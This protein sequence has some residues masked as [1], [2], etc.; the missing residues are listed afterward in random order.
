MNGQNKI[1]N[2]DRDHSE[3]RLQYECEQ[4]MLR[5][6]FKE[7]SAEE[8]WHNFQHRLQQEES[9]KKVAVRRNLHPKYIWIGIVSAA[10]V[11]LAVIYAFH[12]RFFETENTATLFTAIET[13]FPVKV[14]EQNDDSKTLAKTFIARNEAKQVKRGVVFS[15]QMAD[16]SQSTGEG[17]HTTVVSIPYGQVYKVILNDGTEVWLNADSRLEFPSRFVGKRRVVK[18]E[19]EAYFHVARDEE[20][21]FVIKTKK[22]TTQVLGTEFNVKTYKDSDAHVTLVNGSVKVEIP[23]MG[24]DVLLTPGEDITYTGNEIQIKKVDTNY[25]TQWRDGYFYFD[26]VTLADI[27]YEVGRW[28]NVTIEMVKDSSLINQRL[29]FIADRNEDIDQVVENLNAFEYLSVSKN[30]KKLTVRR[31]R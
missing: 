24:K 3:M 25:Y 18:L 5:K 1:E 13:D 2:Q 26:D 16:Y 21:P 4:A 12:A 19:G 31:K 20:K 15:A 30:E 29:H 14:E 28:Y 8:E 9:K 22:L 6:E 7:P 27:L 10:V 23:E 17:A 11:L